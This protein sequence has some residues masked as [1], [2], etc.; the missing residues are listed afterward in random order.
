[1]EDHCKTQNVAKGHSMIS[2]MYSTGIKIEKEVAKSKRA[3]I[4]LGE[5]EGEKKVHRGIG[6]IGEGS[7]LQ[8]GIPPPVL[9][10][11]QFKVYW[12]RIM[13]Q[14]AKRR[15]RNTVIHSKER[16]IIDKVIS[17]CDEEVRDKCLSIPIH[18]ATAHAANYT[19]VRKAT[20]MRIRKK[21]IAMPNEPHTTT[22]KKR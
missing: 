12:L 15:K 6:D 11:K 1:M 4:V 13:E 8:W 16:E 14:N 22:G 18:K 17:I 3:V 19:D 7:V 10:Y 20:V 2:A 9:R 5:S 21:Q